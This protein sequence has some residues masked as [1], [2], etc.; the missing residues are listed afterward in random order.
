M[1]EKLKKLWKFLR[2]NVF[3]K[4]CALAAI[5][6]EIVFWI[7]VWVPILIN[8]ITGNPWWLTVSAAVCLFWAGPFT[9]AVP[10]QIALIIWLSKIL[11]K[12]KEKEKDGKRKFES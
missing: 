7:P 2:K 4:D 12:K 5:I 10:L 1:K 3:N 9:P 8:F 11:N 6:V